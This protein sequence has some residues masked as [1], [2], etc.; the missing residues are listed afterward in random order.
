MLGVTRILK[1]GIRVAEWATP[2]IKDWHRQRNLNQN[3]AHRH[4]QAG[5][6]SLAEQ[7]FQLALEERQ[8]S[9]VDRLELLLGLAE[10][11]RCQSK[12]EEAESTANQ[13]I[14]LALQEKNETLNALALDVLANV[15]LDQQRYAE[16]EKTAREVIRLEGARTKPDHARLASCSRKLASALER[17]ERPAEAIDALKRALSHTEKAYGEEHAETAGHLH[18]LGLLHRL[19]GDHDSAQ[20]CLRRALGIHRALGIQGG[21]GA[22]SQEATETLYNLAASLEESGNLKGAAAE[23]ERMLALRERQVGANPAETAE[24]QVRLAALH[25]RTDRVSSAR[26]L[27]MQALP[28][29]QRKGGPVLAQALETLATAEELSGRGDQARAYREKAMIVAALHAAE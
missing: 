26:E 7:H 21:A 18:E 9:I 22:A 6:W 28:A 3:E 15:Q 14:K 19:H 24:A 25:L 2:H 5:N 16:A 4:L 23:F 12:L 29:L 20:L 8:R 10:A 27:L 1:I 17:S 11:Q 13:A